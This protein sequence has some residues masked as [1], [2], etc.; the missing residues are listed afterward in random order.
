MRKEIANKIVSY[1]NQKF[2]VT[3]S[4]GISYLTA[5]ETIDEIISN[6]IN[7]LKISAEK[8]NIVNIY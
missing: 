7:M 2:M 5:N 1:D 8:K 4:I 3:I 6:S